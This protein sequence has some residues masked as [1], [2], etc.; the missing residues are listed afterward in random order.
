M[1]VELKLLGPGDAD[2]L[3]K[4]ADEVFDNDIRHDMTVAFLDDPRHHLAVAVDDGVV[5]GFASAVRHVHPDKGPE[6][7]INEVAVAPTHQERGVAKALLA[8][9]FEVGRGHQCREAWVLTNRSNI[10]TKALYVSLGGTEME[11]DVLGYEFSLADHG[12]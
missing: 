6:L 2:V 11:D 1:T 3:A 7:W 9:L 12:A 5:I 10:A 8:L 4:V